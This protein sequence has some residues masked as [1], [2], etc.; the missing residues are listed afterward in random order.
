MWPETGTAARQQELEVSL[1]LQSGENKCINYHIDSE[2]KSI[3]GHTWV[4]CDVL[5]KLG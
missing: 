2:K 3:A 5:C 1:I 4:V